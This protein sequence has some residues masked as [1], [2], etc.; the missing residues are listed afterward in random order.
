MASVNK[1]IAVGNVGKEPEIRTTKSG[2]AVAS[3]S[4]ATSERWKDKQSGELKE[5]TEWINATAFGK[6][7]EIV[8]KYVV[9]GSSVYIEGK[10]Q[11]SKYTDANGQEK[12]STKVLVNSLQLLGKKSEGESAPAQSPMNIEEDVPF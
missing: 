12:Y 5:A 6:L 10:L 8:Q 7:A 1:V 4:I 3:F 11:T 9:K 2:E